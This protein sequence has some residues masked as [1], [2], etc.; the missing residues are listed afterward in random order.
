MSIINIIKQSL[1]KGFSIETNSRF[2]QGSSDIQI[3]K[4]DD[5]HDIH[6]W[7]VCPFSMIQ[8]PH[9]YDD[10]ARPSTLKTQI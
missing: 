6:S 4:A 10:R 1:L 3:T 5:R 7:H 9:H 2:V 8:K